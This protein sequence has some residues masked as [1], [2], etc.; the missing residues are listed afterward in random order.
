MIMTA[1][2]DVTSAPDGE[3]EA[4]PIQPSCLLCVVLRY[5]H[6]PSRVPQEKEQPV[7]MAAALH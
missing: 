1:K 7:P 2:Y 5:V 3:A 4:L 6:H